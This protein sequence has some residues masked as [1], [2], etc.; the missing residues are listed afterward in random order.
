MAL[1]SW[2]SWY[3]VA[4][5]WR[6]QPL[7]KHPHQVHRARAVR[8]AKAPLLRG[9]RAALG[10]DLVHPGSGADPE[11]LGAGPRV[12]EQ[13]EIRERLANAME[14]HHPQV[15]LAGRHR[16]HSMGKLVPAQPVKERGDWRQVA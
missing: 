3:L 4:R 9:D 14:G 7:Q 6:A 2:T 8:V 10:L 12:D 5:C 15:I 1:I 13:D 11:E 16:N